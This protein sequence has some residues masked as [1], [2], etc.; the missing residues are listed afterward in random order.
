MTGKISVVIKQDE[1]GCY[2]WC[3]ELKGCQSQGKTVEEPLA[4]IHE[5][6]VLYLATLTGA[7][8]SAP[9]SREIPTTAVEF[10]AWTAADDRGGRRSITLESRRHWVAVLGQS[11]D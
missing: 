6:I 2:A 9:L 8:R 4:N 10:H 3:P 1:D 7:E 5:A 11:S